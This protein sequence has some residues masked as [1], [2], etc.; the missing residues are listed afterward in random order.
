MFDEADM[1]HRYTRARAIADGVLVDVNSTATAAGISYPT[2]LTRAVWD[3]YVRVPEGVEAQDERGRLWDICWL[4]AV[5]ARRAPEGDALIFTVW[6]RNDNEA[7]RPVQLKSSVC[8]RS[9]VEGDK[10]IAT[11]SRGPRC[12]ALQAL[13]DTSVDVS[14][15]EL[16]RSAVVCIPRF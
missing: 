13:A 10:S 15:V 9:R 14:E 3:R 2:A 7:A 5:A 8:R 12:V 6:V 11:Q 16:N 4:L 1:T